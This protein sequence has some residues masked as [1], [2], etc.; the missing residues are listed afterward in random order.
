MSMNNR[1]GGKIEGAK[2]KPETSIENK[3]DE[4]KADDMKDIY[5]YD[6]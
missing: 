2:F 4:I 6:I 3:I 5:P 1:V